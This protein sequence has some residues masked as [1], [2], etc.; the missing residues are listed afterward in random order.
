MADS[1]VRASFDEALI[2]GEVA[3]CD[4]VRLELL[5]SGRNGVEFRARRE[6]LAVLHDCPIGKPEWQRALWVYERLAE[7]GGAHHRAVKHADLLVAAAAEAAGVRVVHYDEDFDRIA[8]V[9][10]Q[11]VRWLAP[12]GSL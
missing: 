6:E 8:A 4:M 12:R 9:T 3:V 2:A 5:H 11:P 7:Q 1:H 10:E